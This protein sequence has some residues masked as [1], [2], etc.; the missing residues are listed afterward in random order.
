[1]ITESKVES[2][3]VLIGS[4]QKAL[5]LSTAKV[6]TRFLQRNL[7][8]MVSFFDVDAQLKIVDSESISTKEEIKIINDWNL[9]FEKKSKK[10]IIICY[11]DP[12]NR[13]LS[14]IIQDVIG[15]LASPYFNPFLEEIFFSKGYTIEQMSVFYNQLNEIV[16]LE[17]ASVNMGEIVTNKPVFAE[18]LKYII[19]LYMRYY[20]NNPTYNFYHN[21]IYLPFVVS[22]FLNPD[23]D[24]NKIKL[25][26][27]DDSKSILNQTLKDYDAVAEVPLTA[28]ESRTITYSNKSHI[29]TLLT[30]NVAE[31]G[32]V[33]PFNHRLSQEILAYNQL[34]LIRK[35]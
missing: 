13:L 24:T 7:K 14:A 10:D 9:I 19:K 25:I 18:M 29:E 31:L 34:E 17:D 35:G 15:N 1:M 2:S 5:F 22:L 8:P 32:G 11:R 27:I 12:Y 6:G 33:T 21:T 26:N 20:L 30:D 23:I 4:S 28:K 16:K 3:N